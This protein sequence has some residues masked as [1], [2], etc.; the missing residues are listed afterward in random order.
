MN[1]IDVKKD[2]KVLTVDD[3]PSNLFV[4]E[5]ILEGEG[6]EILKAASGKEALKYL[7]EESIDLI[8]LDVMMPGMDG[9]Q[10]A[11][12]I[13][14]DLKLNE[15][16]IIFLT[17][18]DDK[19]SVV[20]GFKHGATDYVTKPFDVDELLVRVETQLKL[21]YQAD[22]L[23]KMNQIL[24]Q[25]VQQRTIQLQE[26]SE[27]LAIAYQNLE[28]AYKELNGLDQVKDNF[29]KIIS[30]EIRTPLN[31]IIG[32][33]AL[34]EDFLQEHAEVQ[35]C[36]EL[37]KDGT[38]RMERFSNATLLL[39][40]LQTNR[41][42]PKLKHEI[43]HKI[44]KGVTEILRDSVASKNIQISMHIDAQVEVLVDQ[45]L[46]DRAVLFVIQNAVEHSDHDGKIIITS[47]MQG[48]TLLLQ[49]RDYG[50]GFSETALNSL[51]KP[52]GVGAVHA[53]QSLGLSMK[54]AKVIMEMLKGE[55]RVKNRGKGAEVTFVLPASS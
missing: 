10:T 17:A 24:D 45:K 51:F 49:I 39:T 33:V 20:Q 25:K 32:S 54:T 52:F 15:I 14:N 42:V 44:V 7:G 2:F 38:D 26:K 48:D 4:L 47:I 43:L 1:F 12:H 40:E 37:L 13:I 3:K 8:L 5:S 29:L 50:P 18:R 21:K 53:D 6:Y 30:H 16:P 23:G 28:K 31:A 36:L 35:D 46:F 55:I 9:F 19:E 34:M 11:D 41:Y 22:Q 27:E